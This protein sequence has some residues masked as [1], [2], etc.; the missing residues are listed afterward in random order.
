MVLSIVINVSGH[1]LM[2][3]HDGRR[4]PRTISGRDEV[5]GRRLAVLS[6]D[7]SDDVAHEQ[8]ATGPHNQPKG[9]S[10]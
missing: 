5:V 8:L 9:E 1:S 6:A 10:R 4:R 7:S 2:L 3:R